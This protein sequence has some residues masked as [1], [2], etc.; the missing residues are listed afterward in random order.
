MMSYKSCPLRLAS[1]TGD[2][3]DE[4]RPEP[5]ITGFQLTIW[6]YVCKTGMLTNG[7]ARPCFEEA[8]R[9]EL[10]YEVEEYMYKYHR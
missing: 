5:V 9:R 6:H 8:K 3:V 10:L 1:I 4:S 2:R 7:R